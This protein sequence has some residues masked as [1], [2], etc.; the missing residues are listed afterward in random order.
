MIDSASGTLL[1]R[2]DHL[3]RGSDRAQ[4]SLQAFW[5]ELS[6]D[7]PRANGTHSPRANATHSPPYITCARSNGKYSTQETRRPGP[8]DYN[9]PW[10]TYRNSGNN[11][12]KH[13]RRG[14]GQDDEKAEAL[15]R[16]H[17]MPSHLWIAKPH[18]P[19]E[20]SQVTTP[21]RETSTGRN[22]SSPVSARV[23]N[24]LYK[25]FPKNTPYDQSPQNP[26]T[27]SSTGQQ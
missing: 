4:D 20:L 11:N 8:R 19:N 6:F 16:G 24:T 17:K 3:I 26:S 2:G 5:G 22:K 10:Y 18:S 21:S 25:P 13:Y 14:K 9:R 15:E 1:G 23:F 7:R 12:D 27:D